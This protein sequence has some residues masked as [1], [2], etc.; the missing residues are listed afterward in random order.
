MKEAWDDIHRA[1]AKRMGQPVE[2]RPTT[3]TPAKAA[4]NGASSASGRA[5]TA[6]TGEKATTASESGAPVVEK[7]LSKRAERAKKAAE[8]ALLPKP[9]M[10]IHPGRLAALEQAASDGD[11]E[12]E[13]HGRGLVAGSDDDD[14]LDPGSDVDDDD[15][16]Q[17]ELARLGGAG[18]ASDQSEG[19]WSGSELDADDNDDQDD[20]DN[21]EAAVASDSSFPIAGPS[22][23]AAVT[24]K[25][26]AAKSSTALQK[27][28]NS[29]R[30]GEGS[31]GPSSSRQPVTSSAFL[32]SLA[33]GYISYSDSDGEDAQ[34]V[35][36]AEKGEKKER[37]N[38]RGQRAR[39]A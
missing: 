3:A 2:D 25:S 14:D 8:K 9:S 32:P 6:L 31:R 35:K 15:E 11:A 38:R 27:D 24:N 12:D 19:D 16:I 22:K 17:A 7:R 23:S 39:Q 30:G 29:K 37:K 28:K 10:T 5:N 20:D 26:T 33:G 13:E 18:D 4:I 34:W 1:V 36:D 21:N